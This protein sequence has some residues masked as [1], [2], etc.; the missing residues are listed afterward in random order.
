MQ[1]DTQVE[2][3][4]LLKEAIF[5]EDRPQNAALCEMDLSSELQGLLD[6]FK[7]DIVSFV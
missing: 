2:V 5:A 4:N 7:R 1:R 3:I 6:F